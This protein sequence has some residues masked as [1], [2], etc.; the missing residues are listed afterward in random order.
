MVVHDYEMAVTQ[1]KYIADPGE[2]KKLK[3]AE[4]P[5]DQ[6]AAWNEFWRSRDPSP[7]TVLNELK[8]NYYRRIEYANR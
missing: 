3:K 1:L 6:L 2:T 7:G 4:T 5:D 8:D